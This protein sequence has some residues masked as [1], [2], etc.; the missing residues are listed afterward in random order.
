MVN[1]FMAAKLSRRSMA[2]GPQA[3]LRTMTRAENRPFAG[4]PLITSNVDVAPAPN[5]LR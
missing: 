5:P 3:T 2:G 1:E 4:S